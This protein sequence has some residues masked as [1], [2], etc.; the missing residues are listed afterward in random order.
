MEEDLLK[1]IECLEKIQ[2]E[3]RD[4]DILIW[5]AKNLF[6]YADNKAYRFRIS[7]TATS[8][9]AFYAGIPNGANL[10]GQCVYF[11]E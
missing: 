2:T 10:F 5:Q 9:Y 11:T 7:S 8:A 6:N 3:T 1:A 4:F